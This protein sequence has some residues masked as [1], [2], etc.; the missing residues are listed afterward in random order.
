MN[1]IGRSSLAMVTGNSVPR[2]NALGGQ[3]IVFLEPI[4]LETKVVGRN[5]GLFLV[6]FISFVSDVSFSVG[7]LG[8]VGGTVVWDGRKHEVSVGGKVEGGEGKP[9]GQKAIV[10]GQLC[11]VMDGDPV[12]G[13]VWRRVGAEELVGVTETH[14]DNRVLNGEATG[15]HVLRNNGDIFLFAVLLG[16]VLRPLASHSRHQN[17]RQTDRGQD[18]ETALATLGIGLHGVHSVHGV[19]VVHGTAAAGKATAAGCNVGLAHRVKLLVILAVVEALLQ[20]AQKAAAAFSV[21]LT[22][23]PSRWCSI[24]GAIWRTVPRRVVEKPARAL[25]VVGRAFAVAVQNVRNVASQGS[26]FHQVHLALNGDAPLRLL[27]LPIEGRHAVLG[28][29]VYGRSLT[30]GSNL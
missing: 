26:L 5:N 28:L 6:L 2:A 11:L 17:G 1:L 9:V 22:G 27:L 4:G 12:Q 29:A 30:N 23:S 7:E 14:L 20:E 3:P 13:L 24:R 21:D 8:N 25:L 19:H 15:G 18:K 10:D 16:P